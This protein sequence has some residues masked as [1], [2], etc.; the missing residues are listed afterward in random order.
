MLYMQQKYGVVV[1]IMCF[2]LMY[3][4]KSIATVTWKTAIT[5]IGDSITI[6][7]PEETEKLEVGY[8][9]QDDPALLNFIRQK[10]L[11][12]PSNVPYNLSFPERNDATSPPTRPA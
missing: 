7:R 8:P 3:S 6:F 9:F 4:L 1:S 10:Y 12:A 2:G 5:Q 11:F